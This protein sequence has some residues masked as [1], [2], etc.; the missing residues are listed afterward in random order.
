MLLRSVAFCVTTHP[1][2]SVLVVKGRARE[3]E[4]FL[5]CPSAGPTSE[6]TVLFAG[7]LDRALEASVTLLHRMSQLP[8]TRNTPP[9]NL[10][11]CAEEQILRGSWE[12]SH[13][14]HMLDLLAKEG[15][16][17]RAVVRT[18]GLNAR[19]V[20]DLST[21]ILLAASRPVPVVR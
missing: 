18:P 8:P 6:R 20:D 21:D 12:S 16:A 3:L 5:V 14:S 17:S 2:A 19:L 9:G 13:L 10:E 4:R 1:P 15:P 7:R 11:T